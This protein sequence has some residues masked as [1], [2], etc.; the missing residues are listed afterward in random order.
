MPG[1]RASTE[2]KKTALTSD[3]PLPDDRESALRNRYM[4]DIERRLSAD[5]ILLEG[6]Q[7]RRGQIQIPGSLGHPTYTTPPLATVLASL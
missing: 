1:V 3:M 7:A 4:K 2:E 6:L 5:L